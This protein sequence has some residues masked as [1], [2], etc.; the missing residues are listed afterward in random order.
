MIMPF[1]VKRSGKLRVE[2]KKLVVFITTV[3]GRK[4]IP[5]LALRGT[6]CLRQAGL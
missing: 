4:E 6:P 2:W 3:G 5:A 1:C